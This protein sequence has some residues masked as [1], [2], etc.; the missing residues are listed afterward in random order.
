MDVT[1]EYI[2]DVVFVECRCLNWKPVVPFQ[3]EEAVSSVW[4]FPGVFP[5]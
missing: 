4:V 3:Y 2:A 1:M 5:I